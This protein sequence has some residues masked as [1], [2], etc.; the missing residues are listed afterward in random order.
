MWKID[1]KDK[2]I[3][4]KTSMIKY[5]YNNRATLLNS[6]KEGKEKRMI[7]HQEKHKI[8]EYRGMCIE[9]C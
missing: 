9:S 7:E 5:K 4:K 8:C 1:S 6:G 3:H 2:H